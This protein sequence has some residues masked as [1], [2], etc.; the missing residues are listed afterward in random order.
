MNKIAL[1]EWS[2]ENWTNIY[3]NGRMK[4]YKENWQT[5]ISWEVI[6]KVY[7]QIQFH[8]E[9]SKVVNRNRMFTTNATR[10]NNNKRCVKYN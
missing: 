3:V 6:G 7:A 2:K 1:V 5:T 8:T 4:I 9:K 10:F